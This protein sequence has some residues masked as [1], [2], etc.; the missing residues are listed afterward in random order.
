MLCSLPVRIITLFLFGCTL[1]A[2]SQPA[3]THQRLAWY[4]YFLTLPVSGKSYVQGEIQER[5]FLAPVSQHQALV[6]GRY[7]VRTGGKGFEFSGGFTYMRHSPNDPRAEH[8][9]VTPEI[10]PHFEVARKQAFPSFRLDHRLRFESRS[11][12]RRSADSA[13]DEE[14]FR[15]SAFRIRYRIQ[16][17]YML[18]RLQKE[19]DLRLKLSSE[20]M[21]NIPRRERALQ[22]DQHRAFAGLT[23]VI[24]PGLTVDTGY[25]YLI[26]RIAR[27]QLSSRH[28][29]R[30]TV[31][32]TLGDKKQR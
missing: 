29:F 17:Q 31:F 15:F 11:F 1:P 26:Q 22:F 32:H 12:L 21:V 6:R 27:E 30:L 4:G 2:R 23:T 18:L 28:I 7:H 20:T 14:R 16:I 24:H 8:R 13:E 5:H 10:R 19:R 3:V 25:M 9:T